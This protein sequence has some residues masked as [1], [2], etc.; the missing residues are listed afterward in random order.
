[1]MKT[2]MKVTENIVK[3][4]CFNYIYVNILELDENSTR[5]NITWIITVILRDKSHKIWGKQVLISR[6]KIF[7]PYHRYFLIVH[8]YRKKHQNIAQNGRN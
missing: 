4:L 3:I 8:I 2:K 6:I 1:M 7:R 5:V